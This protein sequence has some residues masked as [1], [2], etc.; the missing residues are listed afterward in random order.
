[1][2]Y[3]ELSGTNGS[4]VAAIHDPDAEAVMDYARRQQEHSETSDEEHFDGADRHADEGGP[5]LEELAEVPQ[6]VEAQ[7]LSQLEEPSAEERERHLLTH[8]PFAPWCESCICGAGR[9]GHHRRKQ[10]TE[11]G[12]LESVVQADYTFFARNANQARVE[13]ESALVTVLTLVDKASGWPLSLQVPRKGAEC[14]NY[15]LNTVEQYLKTLGHEKTTI[16]IDQENALK[17]VANAI[18][19]R[20]GAS[21][22]FVREAPVYS[23]QSQGA[24]EGEHAKVAGL[25][26]T[27]LMDL[28]LTYPTC[29]VDVNHVTF[30]WLVRHAAW[31]TARFQPRTKDHATPYRIVNGVDISGAHMSV[32]GNSHGTS[33]A[34]WRK[35]AA[36]LGESY[37][38]WSLGTR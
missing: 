22:V 1:M 5:G 24:V 8:L 13:D 31:L 10:D 27:I 20:M 32:R 29:S 23:H 38:G 33:A 9:D 26:R 2:H 6:I 25:V 37:L 17:T 36:T 18:Q 21:K 3:E 16:Q 30:P 14:S 34:T 4:Q 19:K 28:Q 15:V 7:G 12:F 35:N 11:D